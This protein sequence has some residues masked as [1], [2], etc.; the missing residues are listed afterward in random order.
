MQIF[1]SIYVTLEKNFFQS[2][3]RK[4]IGNVTFL[5]VLQLI[6]F[7]SVYFNIRQIQAILLSASTQTVANVSAIAERTILQASILLILSILAMI[8]TLLFLRYLVVT[9]VRDLNAQLQA[10]NTGEINLGNRLEINTYD[11]F[12]ELASNYNQFLDQ[13][14]QTVHH[15]RN[16]GINVAVG[17]TTVVHQVQ[18]VSGQATSQGELSQVVFANSQE[19]TQT[20]GTISDHA[21]QV[22]SSTSESL[23]S[24][25]DALGELQSVNQNM[26]DMLTQIKRHD[27]TIQ[28]MGDKSRDIGKIISIIQGI[29]FQ[30]GL[31]SLNAAVE[32]AR[33]G[34]AGKGFSV[35]ATEVKKLAEQANKASEQIAGQINDILAS[36]DSALGEA[37]AINRAAERTMEVSSMTSSNYQNLI[38]E[39]DEN[40]GRL[41]HIT[42]SVEEI[43]AANQQTHEKVSS[44]CELSQTVREQTEASKQIAI[45]LQ[46]TSESMQQLVARF[47]TGEGAFEQILQLARDFQTGAAEQIDN[48][49][50]R[51]C[52]VFDTAYQAIPGTHPPKYSTAYDQEF[53]RQLQPLYDQT[54]SQLPEGIFAIC[55]DANGYGPT[56]NSMFSKPLTGD[57]EQDIHY[58][59]EKRIFNDTTGLRSARNKENFL[60]QTY[61][62]DTG[63]VLSDLSMPIHIQGR[64]WG[65]IRLGFSPHVLQS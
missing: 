39:F 32:A 4:L 12:R 52:H 9:P 65:A 58:S 2:L 56:H 45:D 55:V 37:S 29:S 7:I 24:A 36:I 30:T 5:F 27:Q 44:I 50:T 18:N 63:E 48:L 46:D 54:L 31:L 60:L 22:A 26:Q 43:S 21:Q 35:V 51:G 33:A 13:L 53:A 25:R 20:L 62:R 47:I 41:S 28:S 64:H 15:L 17:A 3:T 10:M 8:G 61:M 57:P 59:R 14:R 49:A 19:A 6:L 11:E 42:A 40:Y 23:N 34:Q 38:K 16:L 1:R